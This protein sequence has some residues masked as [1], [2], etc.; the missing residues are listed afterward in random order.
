LNKTF[1]EIHRDKKN[2]KENQ[3][4]NALMNFRMHVSFNN[5]M[6]LDELERSR[7]IYF[8]SSSWVGKSLLLENKLELIGLSEQSTRN[9]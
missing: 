4:E 3:M 2:L 5:V 8:K 7:R 1:G 9:M 6:L